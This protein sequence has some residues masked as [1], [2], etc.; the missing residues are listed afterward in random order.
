M[1]NSKA[2]A[3]LSVF[4]ESIPEVCNQRNAVLPHT[5]WRYQVLH[6]WCG[7][8]NGTSGE[9]IFSA[10]GSA[11]RACA[12]LGLDSDGTFGGVRL[13]T[14]PQGTPSP[15]R[16]SPTSDSATASHDRV[17][18]CLTGQLRGVP[19]AMLNWQRGS[20]LSLL[21]AGRLHIDWFVVTPNSTA[22]PVWHPFIESLRPV[23]VALLRPDAVFDT[24]AKATDRWG[25]RTD[26]EG[27]THFNLARF[28]YFGGRGRDHNAARVVTVLIQQLQ[29]ATCQQAIDEHEKSTGV[30]YKRV[31]RLRTDVLFTGLVRSKAFRAMVSF[32]PGFPGPKE[33]IL[34]QYANERNLTAKYVACRHDG[35]RDKWET[36]ETDCDAMLRRGRQRL[37]RDCEDHLSELEG[38]G[39]EWLT[40]SDLW[41]FGSRDVMMNHYLQTLRI[42]E[43][44]GD[45]ARQRNLTHT[46]EHLRDVWSEAWSS[47]I[48]HLPKERHPRDAGVCAIAMAHTEIVRTAGPPVRRFFLQESEAGPDWAA[49]C[50]PLYSLEECLHA[51]QGLWALPFAAIASCIGLTYDLVPGWNSSCSVKELE[52]D[53]HRAHARSFGLSLVGDLEGWAKGRMST[54]IVERYRDQIKYPG[55]EAPD[56]FA[57][58]L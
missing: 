20:L 39:H 35:R 52:D 11:K 37:T 49:T 56:G 26:D 58:N 44:R 31:A 3:A 9:P 16:D 10:G 53:L 19:L 4:N 25:V 50:R 7:P 13:A 1:A 17:A 38:A 34:K 46:F 28:P 42:L 43:E 5:C 32:E 22:Y 23:R 30:R 29:M 15:K 6:N 48:E 41:M 40:G 54:A 51:Q 2:V 57:R 8:V 12:A 45:R 27:R 14:L 33:T 47:A 36:A 21:S 18:V 55:H 24:K